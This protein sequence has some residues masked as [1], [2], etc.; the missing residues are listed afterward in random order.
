MLVHSIFSVD[1]CVLKNPIEL[2]LTS[3]RAYY[4]CIVWDCQ[5][6]VIKCQVFWKEGIPYLATNPEGRHLLLFFFSLIDVKRTQ[7]ISLSGKKKCQKRTLLL[8]KKYRIQLR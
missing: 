7:I 3:E 8:S 5:R 6:V 4:W 1:L 2:S